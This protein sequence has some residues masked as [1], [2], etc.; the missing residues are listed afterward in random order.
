MIV[1]WGKREKGESLCGGELR[2][3]IIVRAG[4]KRNKT[5]NQRRGGGMAEDC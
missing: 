2:E 5:K 4:I 1:V 3:G